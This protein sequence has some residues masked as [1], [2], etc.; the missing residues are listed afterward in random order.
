MAA[1]YGLLRYINTS[2]LLC[3]FMMVVAA[4]DGKEWI[5]FQMMSKAS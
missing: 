4:V 3:H 1:V 2:L 5:I